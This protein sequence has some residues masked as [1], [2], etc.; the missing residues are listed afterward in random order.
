MITHLHERSGTPPRWSPAQ[1]GRVPR[2]VVVRFCKYFSCKPS[3][4]SSLPSWGEVTELPEANILQ[5]QSPQNFKQNYFSLLSTWPVFRKYY[6]YLINFETFRD[7]NMSRDIIEN[8]VITRA[9][10]LHVKRANSRPRVGG[11]PH[12]PGSPTSM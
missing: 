5:K 11:L 8:A 7:E 2:P 1:L 3:R 10:R 12:L 9:S 4:S 6:D